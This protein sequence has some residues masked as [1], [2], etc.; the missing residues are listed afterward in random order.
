MSDDAIAEIRAFNRFYTRQLGLL[1]EHV[2]SSP[3]TLAE[4]R[5]LYEIA[6]RG[7]VTAAE[8]S[9]ALN[10][11]PAYMSRLRQRLISAGLVAITPKAGDRR[12]NELALTPDGDAAFADLD[13]GSQA[14][15]GELIQPLDSGKKAALVAAMKSIR[16]L[17]GD[18]VPGAPVVLRPHRIGDL[19][20][21][22]HR[23]GRL[24]HEA[25]GWN[26]E[27]EALVAGLYRDFELAPQ[28]PPKALWVAE[29]AGEIVG[30]IFCLPS[31]GLRGSAQLRMLYVEPSAR[32]AGLGRLL[33][34]QCV[35]FARSSGYERIRLWTQDVLVSARRIYQAAGF[36]QQNTKPHHSFGHD[37]VGET[38]ELRF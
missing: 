5:L 9:R 6:A 38:W 3:F 19:G 22:V 8:L 15:I 1:D 18:E 25:H 11:D 33:V 24:Y 13:A 4:G 21:L 26:A 16:A 10:L 34:D 12:A 27:F 30:S 14:A 28:S 2:T 7:H 20:W 23:Q 36:E 32:G 35:A 37:L 29:R 31:E 17:L